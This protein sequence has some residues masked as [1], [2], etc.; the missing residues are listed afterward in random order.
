[1]IKVNSTSYWTTGITVAWNPRAQ[2]RDKVHSP[3]WSA[4]L[5][6]FDDGFCDDN[7]DAGQVAT[8]GELRTRYFVA[9]G[10]HASGLGVA[11]DV[12]LADAQRMGITFQ[13]PYLYYKGDGEN[14]EYP[15]PDGWKETLA[16]QAKRLG[17]DTPYKML[18]AIK[19]RRKEITS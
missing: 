4:S 17:W 12:L 15:A 10:V 18:D 2:Y 14:E 9:D 13:N 8:Q 6:F 7:A 11:L 1:M 19:A 3:G 16:A 5:E